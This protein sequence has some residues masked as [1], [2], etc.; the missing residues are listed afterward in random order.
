MPESGE[1]LRDFPLYF[2][3]LNLITETPEHEL[4]TDIYLPLK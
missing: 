2:H 3:Y 4:I 1:D